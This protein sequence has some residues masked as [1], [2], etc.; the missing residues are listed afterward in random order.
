L[1]RFECNPADG[2]ALDVEA[3]DEDRV[4]ELDRVVEFD[5]RCNWHRNL[6]FNESI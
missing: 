2:K 6:Q 3:S 1:V 4:V 5:K